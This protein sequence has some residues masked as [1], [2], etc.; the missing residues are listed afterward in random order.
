MFI[1]RVS[2]LPHASVV[3]YFSFHR[4]PSSP[5]ADTYFPFSLPIPSLYPLQNCCTDFF[6]NYNVHPNFA[7]ESA[8]AVTSGEHRCLSS[9]AYCFH[10][11]PRSIGSG[12]REQ[13]KIINSDPPHIN[14]IQCYHWTAPLF[15][16]LTDE[17][18]VMLCDW[19]K[20]GWWWLQECWIKSY[21]LELSFVILV[22]Y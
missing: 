8:E 15:C 2:L 3:I 22:L 21:E 5:K 4:C 7:S 14:V 20:H 6:Y 17:Q 13:I 9:R 11:S 19:S 18:L 10:D 16:V 12:M 1:C